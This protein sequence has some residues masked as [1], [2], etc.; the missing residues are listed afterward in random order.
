MLYRARNRYFCFSIHTWHGLVFPWSCQAFLFF[1]Q[2]L[3]PGVI[4]YEAASRQ[5]VAFKFSHPPIFTPK[6]LP[7][8]DETLDEFR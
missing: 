5:Q 6:L 3:N 7:A 4:S 2:G 8:W 1:G